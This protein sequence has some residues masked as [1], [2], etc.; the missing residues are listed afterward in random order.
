[1]VGEVL[2]I[3]TLVSAAIWIV[4]S[5]PPL[6][7]IRHL[8]MVGL[9]FSLATLFLGLSAL[10][11][12]FVLNSTDL[13]VAFALA[14]VRLE[15]LIF[16][17]TSILYFSRWTTRG[18]GPRDIA[19]LVAPGLTAHL[20][21]TVM[22]SGMVMAPWG[23]RLLLDP[24]YYGL[25]AAQ[26]VGYDLLAMAYLIRG[27]RTVLREDQ[28][29][30]LPITA[31]TV[32]IGLV[33]GLGLSTN[34]LV[35]LE[36]SGGFPYFSSLLLIPGLVLLALMLLIPKEKVMQ[37]W[38]R[39]ALGDN[40][41]VLAACLLDGDGNLLGVAA[42]K[43]EQLVNSY[44]LPEVLAV[45]DSFISTAFRTSLQTL[46]TVVTGDITYLVSKGSRFF[47]VLVVQGSFHDYLKVLVREGLQRLEGS[48]R[49]GGGGSPAAAEASF[50]VTSFLQEFVQPKD[51]VP[52][53]LDT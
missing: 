43:A 48:V 42:S 12:W 52:D 5:L 27:S 26:V 3:L 22:S 18:R 36:D 41:R 19:L 33:V 40:R 51:L 35:N 30:A 14:R 20:D 1:M 11:D 38:R 53:I 25:Y 50:N 7:S 21:W 17:S 34:I 29:L 37:A 8:S 24:L 31:F 47:L 28:S 45:I 13:T 44:N 15:C 23:P 10:L 49:S 2:Y 46:R 39:V 4:L 16:S 9:A 32:A 6:F